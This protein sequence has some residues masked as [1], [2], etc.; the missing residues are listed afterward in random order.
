MTEYLDSV[1]VKVTELLDLGLPWEQTEARVKNILETRDEEKNL[2]FELIHQNQRFNSLKHKQKYP[3]LV[4][5]CY[6]LGIGTTKDEKKPLSIGKRITR[7]MAT[8]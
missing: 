3:L 2:L 8:I 4:G 7:L 1:L 6:N 5:F